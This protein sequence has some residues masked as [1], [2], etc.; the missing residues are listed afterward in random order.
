MIRL[1][2]CLALVSLLTTFHVNSA[3][4]FFSETSLMLLPTVLGNYQPIT[5][6]DDDVL[7]AAKF[8]GRKLSAGNTLKVLKAE[9]QLIAGLNY[10]LTLQLAEGIYQVRVYQDVQHHL[11]LSY[12]QR[13]S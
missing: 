7:R 8:A 1:K 9:R 2:I 5:T 4:A 11:T 12:A 10:Q 6:H 13:L 3:N